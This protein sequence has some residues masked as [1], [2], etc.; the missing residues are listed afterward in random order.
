QQEEKASHQ[1]IAAEVKA[2]RQLIAARVLEF[3]V[4]GNGTVTDIKTGLMWK[5]MGE[6]GE[7][8]WDEAIEFN[9]KNK[10]VNFGG[11]SDWRLPNIEELKSLL[12]PGAPY[13]SSCY[14]C[15]DTFPNG[16]NK[17]TFWSSSPCGNYSWCVRF[18][19]NDGDVC[20]N[21]RHYSFAVRLVRTGQ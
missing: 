8:T 5:R 16:N 18:G 2:E 19:N 7:F 4:N 3:V 6:E 12:L 21:Y 10:V 14:I 15:K 9:G 17:Y 11:F 13:P 1:L 20:S